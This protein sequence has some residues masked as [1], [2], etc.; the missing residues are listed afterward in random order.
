M[1]APVSNGSCVKAGESVSE[2]VINSWDMASLNKDIEL[3]HVAQESTEVCV[4]SAIKDAFLNTMKGGRI[5]SKDR[6]PLMAP[7]R[8]PVLE[9][10]RYCLYFVNVNIEDS[11]YRVVG[12]E[13]VRRRGKQY[14]V[15]Q[16]LV[17]P[18]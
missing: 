14:I 8:G 17:P 7:A 2:F 6:Y 13:R 5:S 11:L 3:S 4:G 12:C 1:W 16:E 9:C 18:S 15:F 10:N